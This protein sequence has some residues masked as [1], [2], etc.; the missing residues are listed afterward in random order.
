MK[1]AGEVA[2]VTGA[3]RGIGR[4]I[5]EMQAQEGA[6]VALIARTAA[7]VE[8]AADAIRAAGGIARPM[9]STSSTARLWRKPSPPSTA[10]SAP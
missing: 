6:R 10:I 2:V 1:L 4:A 8:A 7:E 3:G 5:A 9:P